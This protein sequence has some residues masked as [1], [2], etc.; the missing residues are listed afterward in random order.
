VSRGRKLQVGGDMDD[1]KIEVR[2]VK[3][4]KSPRTWAVEILV[5]AAVAIIAIVAAQVL[6][7]P[8][9]G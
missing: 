2:L 8:L 1:I 3:I 9:F 5:N 4:V 7:V 6:I